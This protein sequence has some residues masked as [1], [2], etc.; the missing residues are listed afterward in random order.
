[1]S[2]PV[3][4]ACP[5]AWVCA[6]EVPARLCLCLCGML[7]TRAPSLEWGLVPV[8]EP[9][10][11]A[12]HQ[13]ARLGLGCGGGC[14]VPGYQA[15][16]VRV[17]EAVMCSRLQAARVLSG[18]MLSSGPAIQP[19]AG[20]CRH[21]RLVCELAGWRDPTWGTRLQHVWASC[22]RRNAGLGHPRVLSWSPFLHPLAHQAE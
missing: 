8:S 13:R 15:F 22:W 1:M 11:G 7:S 17:L 9:V 10:C 6:R 5:R 2:V 21:G 4:L 18:C 3:H 20:L 14:P 12:Q 16:F 19:S